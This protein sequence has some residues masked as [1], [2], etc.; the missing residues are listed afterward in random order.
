MMSA[1]DSAMWAGSSAPS[2]CDL[3]SIGGKFTDDRT[4]SLR[5]GNPGAHS[6]GYT[7]VRHRV[8]AS[9]NKDWI[10]TST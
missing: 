3:S 10:A 8:S 4:P 2:I 7:D 5:G 6:S 9:R 1:N